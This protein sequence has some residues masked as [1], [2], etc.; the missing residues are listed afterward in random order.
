MSVRSFIAFPVSGGLKEK[1]EHVIRDLQRASADVRWVKAQNIHLT[2]KFLGDVQE[3]ALEKISSVIEAMSCDFTPLT[4]HLT[5]I[6][7]FPNGDYPKIIWGALDDPRKAVQGMAG[8]LEKG[9]VSCGIPEEQRPFQ[10]HITLGRVRSSAR[11]KDLMRLM[12]QMTFE[13]KITQQFDKIILY[14]STLTPQGP[15]YEALKVF[16]MGKG[17]GASL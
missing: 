4:A 16:E 14:K 12:G 6:G 13:D 3:N 17:R 9:L 11:L 10:P 8:I 7:T 1:F 2:L 15:V 5:A